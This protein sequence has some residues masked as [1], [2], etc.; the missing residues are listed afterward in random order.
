M[1]HRNDDYKTN[2]VI[3]TTRVKKKAMTMNEES[4][5]EDQQGNHD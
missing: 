2:N 3:T 1:N 4:Q 5:L